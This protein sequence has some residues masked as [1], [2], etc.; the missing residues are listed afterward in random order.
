[1]LNLTPMLS[2]VR[3]WHVPCVNVMFICHL[4][5]HLSFRLFILYLILTFFIRFSFLILVIAFVTMYLDHHSII[6]K[7][8]SIVMFDV[9]VCLCT[10]ALRSFAYE[11]CPPPLVDYSADAELV[12]LW[13][14]HRF[15]TSLRANCSSPILPRYL[16][17]PITLRPDCFHV[18]SH[19]FFTG[20]ND[21]PP[22]PGCYPPT[23]LEVPQ[24]I[25]TDTVCDANL[26][27]RDHH[28]EFTLCSLGDLLWTRGFYRFEDGKVSFLPAACSMDRPHRTLD[29]NTESDIPPALR[30][31]GRTTVLVSSLNTSAYMFE[32]RDAGATHYVSADSKHLCFGYLDDAGLCQIRTYSVQKLRERLGLARA[33][34]NVSVSPAVSFFGGDRH[35]YSVRPIRLAAFC[36]NIDASS[37]SFFS[38]LTGA[39]VGALVAVLRP[40]LLVVFQ[41][42]GSLLRT[43]V[44][45]LFSDD[46]VFTLL[47]FSLLHASL[48]YFTGNPYYH[49]LLLALFTYRTLVEG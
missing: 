33:S 4:I 34:L 5:F 43:L 45:T 41:V 28:L 24:G 31:A 23:R 44:H 37:R 1:M 9:V 39:V 17:A 2:S 13:D 22:A 7:Y 26:P 15:I 42:L 32:P 12:R 8:N 29:C 27:P 20:G 11:P 36:T 46:F 38:Q 16:L 18:Y 49:A 48:Y 25:F 10:L 30:G 21:C 19:Y 35:V 3:Y 47:H 40:V 14:D 6:R